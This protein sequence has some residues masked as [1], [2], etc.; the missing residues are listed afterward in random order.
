M[1]NHRIL[2]LDNSAVMHVLKHSTDIKRLKTNE[3]HTYIIHNYLFRLQFLIKKVKPSICVFARDSR[4]SK[5]QII[6]PEY[7]QKRKQ[8]KKPEQIKLD[9]IAYP[10]FSEIEKKLLPMLGYKNIFITNGLEADDIIASICKTNKNSE[11][12]IVTTDEDLYQLLSNTTCILNARS[13]KIFTRHDFIKKYKIEP[14]DWKKVKS[15]AGCKS[16]NVP[17]LKGVGEKTIINYLLG[18]LPEHHQ[19]YKRIKDPANFDLIMRNKK[20]V[21]L[22]FKD[23][24][25]YDIDFQNI[26]TKKGIKKVGDYYNFSPIQK[27]FKFWCKILRGF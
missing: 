8:N 25:T 19:T 2:L 24:P 23:T 11:I 27:D 22:P 7:K 17:G 6:L 9:K 13:S 12:F 15:V 26:P 1:L 10:Q 3:L 5:R 18:S 20:L 14:K 4:K 21:C 16:D